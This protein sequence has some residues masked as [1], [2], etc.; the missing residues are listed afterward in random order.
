MWDELEVNELDFTET[1]FQCKY[2]QEDLEETTKD[3]D[4]EGSDTISLRFQEQLRGLKQAIKNTEQSD[5]CLPAPLAAAP[6]QR[7]QPK[8]GEAGHVPGAAGD[9]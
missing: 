4:D 9:E 1:G 8:P 5:F 3:L 6:P 7:T 2:C